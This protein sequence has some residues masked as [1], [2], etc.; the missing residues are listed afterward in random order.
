MGTQRPDWWQEVTT[1]L[2]QA[3][4]MAET[5]RAQWL[6]ALR[7]QNPELATQ[8][9][10][11]L[12]D[13]GELNKQGFLEGEPGAPPS[14]GIPRQTI[15]AYT[16][17]SP[18][19]QGGMGSVWLAERNDGRFERQVAVKFLSIGL[20]GRGGEQRFKREGSILG[21]LAHPH[22]A[23]LVDAGVSTGGQPYLVLEYVDGKH[24]NEYCD[25]H[26]LDVDGRVRLF[27][28]VMAAVEHAHAHLI[29]HR[30]IKPSNVLVRK[31]GR[32]KLLD[33]GI[34][35]LLEGEGETGAATLLTREGGAA[36]T[37]EFASPEQITGQPVTTAT[38]VYALGVLLYVLLTGRHPAGVNRTSP[39][40]LVKAITEIDPPNMSGV[41]AEVKSASE[42]TASTTNA[43][44]RGTTPAKLSKRLRGDLDTIVAK[45]M[46]KKPAERYASVSAFAD[47]LRRSLANEPIGARPDSLAYRTAKFVQRNRRTVAL[48]ALALL[49]AIAG[50]TG[51][52][53][54]ARTAREQRDFAYRQLSRAEVINDL[55]SFLLS[56]AAPSGK[57][58]TVD[59]LLGRAEL[60]LERAAG[61]GDP[62]RAELLQSIGQQYA[63]QEENDK[64]RKL[65]EQAYA[66]SR[67]S[68]DRSMRARAS[69]ALANA[70][71]VGGEIPRA[72]RLVQE[73]LAELPEQ[74][75]YA[76]DRV[77]CFSRGSDV[78]REAGL[79]KQ[80]I[81][82][83]QSALKTL[84]A[85]PFDNDFLELRVHMDLAE[86]YRQAGQLQEAISEF[87]QSAKTMSAL[88]RDETQTAGTLY[89][90]WGLALGQVGRSE[91]AERIL[92]RA[93]DVSRTDDNEQGVS[94]MV[95]VNYA[96]ALRDL[97]RMEQASTYA[98]RGYLSA[99]KAGH[100][101]A[102]NQA[103]LLRE[104]IY[105]DMGK[106]D[107]AQAMLDEVE[108]RL[109]HDLPPGHYAFASVMVERAGVADARGDHQAAVRMASQAIEMDQAAIQS[110]GQGKQ[111][112]P[113]LFSRRSRFE[114]GLGR[115]AEAVAD[116]QHALELWKELEKP[117]VA[118]T[119]LG[120]G[121]LFLG[122][123]LQA[124]GKTEDA[125][126]AFLSAAENLSATLGPG[127]PDT[128]LALQLSRSDT[129]AVETK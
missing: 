6:K 101:V 50:V 117:G 96:S 53:L 4:G 39:A 11:L 119:I 71:A 123:A 126:A 43:E 105:L 108:P 25:E 98:E 100:N 30:D 124:Q 45:A 69:C 106:L 40:E 81:E 76:L 22:I 75:Q 88:G 12:D 111:M 10:I 29:V 122:R 42:A 118:S 63:V 24:I 68:S 5:D 80:G 85:S 107:Q 112:L 26:K 38:D 41:V 37:P 67:S 55:N 59:E 92:R 73:G 86:A 46:K 93:I 95:L 57:P 32:V 125:R 58:F 49:A 15:D 110:G 65:L 28:D 62:T 20:T 48:A 94:P 91:E 70:L 27:L 121:Y 14:T 18:A 8:L 19:G 104:R 36:L 102:A 103:L 2:D 74:T 77:Y 83:V 79:A 17:L 129:Q 127:H 7:A 89:N 51:T 47:D 78:A 13:H 72:E 56:D 99:K 113:M 120:R 97:R 34:A 64:A 44:K 16:L 35:K 109:K 52:L 61:H 66:I 128:L 116:A 21:R 31:D 33:F 115:P 114:V 87:E 54:Q 60:I 3:L 82:R 9:Q 90:N 1:Y 84:R 23:E